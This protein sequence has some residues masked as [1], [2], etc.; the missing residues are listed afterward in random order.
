MDW[1]AVGALSGLG[2][3]VVSVVAVVF[4]GLAHRRAKEANEAAEE[5]NRIAAR[6]LDESR[7]ANEIAQQAN[8]LSEATKAISEREF[9]MRHENVVINWSFQW[10]RKG[11]VLRVTNSGADTAHEVSVSVSYKD[12]A[13]TYGPFPEVAG[14]GEI[15]IELPEL[16]EMRR[17]HSSQLTGVRRGRFQV[18]AF[19]GIQY[20]TPMGNPVTPELVELKL[21]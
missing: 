12:F 11:D 1:T 8:E 9:A 18:T 16:A 13:E 3:A 14:L 17:Q 6:G 21:R 19:I 2:A 10:D 20:L 5:A 4:A 15:A 7:V